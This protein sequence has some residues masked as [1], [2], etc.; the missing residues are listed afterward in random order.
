M[1]SLKIMTYMNIYTYILFSFYSA[2][3][4]IV[5]INDKIIDLF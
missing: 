1:I 4:I 2:H 5:I 3:D